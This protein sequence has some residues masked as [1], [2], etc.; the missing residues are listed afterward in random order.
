MLR[1]RWRCDDDLPALVAARGAL[2]GVIL[3][4]A[5]WAA[6]VCLVAVTSRSLGG[7]LYP[8]AP[9]PLP[10]ASGAVVG[11]Y[12]VMAVLLLLSIGGA[13][14]PVPTALAFAGWAGAAWLARRRLPPPGAFLR[15]TGRRPRLRS[16]A[17]L[18][19]PLAL[20]APYLLRSMVNP[21]RAWD[22]LTY[23][24]VRAASWAQAVGFTV[25]PAPDHWTY[26]QFYATGGDLL[27]AWAFLGGR[28]DALL[29]LCHAFVE[30][31]LLAAT[32]VLARTL[33]ARARVAALASAFVGSLPAVVHFTTTAYVDNLIV[34]LLLL[35]CAFGARAWRARRAD[36]DLILG[37][38]ALGSACVIK[39]SVITLL[40]LHIALCAWLVL[41]GR[42]RAGVQAAACGLMLMPAVAWGLYL[43]RVTGSPVYPVGIGFGPPALAEGNALWRGLLDGSA[44][45]AEVR[46][47]DL[48][49]F[50]REL[51]VGTRAL[52]H[53]HL[54]LGVG[55]L[56]VIATGV[57]I[58][59]LGLAGRRPFAAALPPRVCALLLI[60]AALPV[61]GVLSPHAVALR[62]WWSPVTGR[63]LV[64]TV[65][66]LASVVAARRDGATPWVLLA[67]LALTVPQSLPLGLRAGEI[68]RAPAALAVGVVLLAVMAAPFVMASPRRRAVA[69]VASVALAPFLT[70]ALEGA[71][72]PLRYVAYG[73]AGWGRAYDATPIPIGEQAAVWQAL[74]GER[75]TVIAFVAGYTTPSYQWFRYPLFG[76]RLQ[77]RVLYVSPRGDGRLPETWPTGQLDPATLD[78]D[79]WAER[80][81]GAGVEWIVLAVPPPAETQ[82]VFG[83]PDLFE[84]VL[85]SPGHTYVVARLRRR[86][87]AGA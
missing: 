28:G 45:P 65:G 58:L 52:G 84:H 24:L 67:A 12:V 39:N 77:N 31:L 85:T 40:A 34:A 10:S 27:Y 70:A 79:A 11:T 19:L 81:R 48:S 25:A 53:G 69:V 76:R 29:F 33:G 3:D 61:A 50:V 47:D 32:F 43:F 17:A 38:L 73:E 62:T 8:R 14:R 83:R 87:L 6:S 5:L 82:L 46:R 56:P 75:G 26:Y 59:A 18:G 15:A 2:T 86:A 37:A 22:A 57:A 7:R 36:T 13:L 63:L 60:V 35:Y 9:W 68:T 41:R 30:G 1:S 21:P 80:L 71:R 44:A 23:H 4:T 55:S 54:N 16:L 74:D 78:A 20:L 51:F 72:A 49:A 64:P 42:A 66:I